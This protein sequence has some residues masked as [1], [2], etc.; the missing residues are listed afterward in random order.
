MEF[1][2]AGD[3]AV[4]G[5]GARLGGFGDLKATQGADISMARRTSSSTK[6]VS[7]LSASTS[8]FQLSVRLMPTSRSR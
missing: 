5:S 3:A 7:A 4:D 6:V 2:S 1:P 8:E